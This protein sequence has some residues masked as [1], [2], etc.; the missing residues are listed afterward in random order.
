MTAVSGMDAPTLPDAQPGTGSKHPTTGT[1]ANPLL[2]VLIS[3]AGTVTDASIAPEAG[4]KGGEVPASALSMAEVPAKAQQPSLASSLLLPDKPLRQSAFESSPVS[5]IDGGEQAHVSKIAVTTEP[6]PQGTTTPEVPEDPDASEG[7]NGLLPTDVSIVLTPDTM[8]SSTRA[9]ADAVAP[10]H[11][12]AKS[13]DGELLLARAET[14]PPAAPTAASASAAAGLQ[15]IVASAT[16]ASG[17]GEGELAPEQEA[18][19]GSEAIDAR[20]A[21]P[22]PLQVRAAADPATAQPANATAV[23]AAGAD[24]TRTKP[25]P[26]ATEGSAS[27]SAPTDGRAFADVLRAVPANTAPPTAEGGTAAVQQMAQGAASAPAPA[28]ASSPPPA[29]QAHPTINAKPGQIG[30][31]FGVEI[32]RTAT[33]GLDE[34]T[35]RLNPAELGRIEVKLSFD[36]RGS[37]RAVVAAENPA[38][39]D[40]LR[41]DSAELNRALADAGIRSDAGSFRFDSRAGSG[42]EGGQFWQRQQQATRASGRSYSDASPTG[43]DP[44]YRPLRTSGRV[45][46][47]A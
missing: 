16:K 29:A 35:V 6:T 3:A 10:T 46:L 47:M 32:A 36:E 37:L 26:A 8:V 38:A 1:P 43:E 42:G 5:I 31:E 4:A 25:A 23:E 30:Q 18:S 27:A 11:V 22:L 14:L 41:R 13:E 21:T 44:V 45:D 40:M 15:P 12:E 2:G 28:P 9:Q 20:P 24:Q 17:T 34:L 33:A 39:L 7:A 19:E